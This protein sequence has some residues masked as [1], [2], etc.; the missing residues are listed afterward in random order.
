MEVKLQQHVAQWDVGCV[1]SCQHSSPV[2]KKHKHAS[3]CMGSTSAD[4][5]LKISS[6]ICAH[7]TDGESSKDMSPTCYK[8]RD[9]SSTKPSA[10]PCPSP[11]SLLHYSLSLCMGLQGSAASCQSPQARFHPASLADTLACARVR[12]KVKGPLAVRMG[13]CPTAAV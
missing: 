11:T 3:A 4:P 10:T 9:Q 6:I 5:R 12:C 13:S 7:A 2:Q 8:G 1:Q